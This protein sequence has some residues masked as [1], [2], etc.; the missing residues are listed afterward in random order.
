M[1]RR[2]A[3]AFFTVDS[4]RSNLTPTE[5]DEPWGQHQRIAIGDRHANRK[6]L[7]PRGPQALA[8]RLGFRYRTLN[9]EVGGDRT[10]RR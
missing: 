10:A 1:L 7:S 2:K 9:R 8:P 4:M 6:P 5:A 3:S